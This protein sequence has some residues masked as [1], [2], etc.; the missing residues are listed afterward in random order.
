VLL[1]PIVT[2]VG[3]LAEPVSIAPTTMAKLGVVDERFQSYNVEI[4]EVTGGRFWKPYSSQRRPAEKTQAAASQ[5]GGP[6]G[7]SPDLFEYRPPIDLSNARLRK[8]AA[9]LG[10]AYVRVSG[11]W[12]NTVYFH[13]S[14]EPPPQKPP[15]G[16]NAVL[17]RQQ[18][19][20]VIDFARAVD[21]KIMTSFA[22]GPGT[23]D[24]S[25]VWT[26]EQARRMLAYTR[27]AGG[28]IAAVEF[29]NEPNF[30]GMGGTPKGYDADA[31]AR[32]VRAFRTFIKDA[33]PD[34]L[35][36]GPGSVGEGG[37][38]DTTTT[39]GRLKTEDLLK[40]SGPVYDAFSYHLYAAVSRRC[41]GQMPALG[42]TPDAALSQE[43][44]SRAEK[45][46]AAYAEMRDQ[47]EAGKPLWLTE[48]ADAAC[49]GN[50]WATTFRDT[51]RYLNQHARLAQKGVE[52][53]AHNTLA[54][55]D[56]GLLD[57]HTFTPRPNYW[58]AVL[59]RRLMGRT[60][61]NAGPVAASD[62]YVYAHCGRDRQGAVT[63]LAINAAKTPQEVTTAIGGERYTLT[64]A[65]LESKV[66]QLN[67]RELKARE[68]GSLP[69]LTGV[70]AGAGRVVLPPFSITFL[71]FP[72]A[73]NEVCQ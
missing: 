43:W 36:L 3:S 26:P 24:A 67:G 6:A 72:Q 25:G 47:F 52:M 19:K 22:V 7:V 11:T 20:G 13:D 65:D 70:R 14:D 17:T 35:F 63:V 51:F 73:G 5:A 4:V 55:S 57:E 53:I 45:I 30:A 12:A 71:A 21:G 64:A 28:S 31:Y 62:L 48:T 68:D 42:T 49:G 34:A 61:L 1:I 54:A 18:W 9:A 60:V 59:W 2:A 23:R 10:P 8:L 27:A 15:D 56:Y 66:L 40:A 58:A 50:P 44:L 37:V 32:D 38:L 33:A 41:A 39:P 16:F 46:H 29:M 69:P